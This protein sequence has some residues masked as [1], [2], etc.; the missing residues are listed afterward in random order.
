MRLRAVS[1]I[2]LAFVVA[3]ASCAAPAEPS[4]TDCTSPPG[5][6][7]T[8]AP[9]DT[10]SVP[11][12]RPTLPSPI[13]SPTVTAET[14]TDQVIALYSAGSAGQS[15]LY[16]L[17]ADGSTTDL[18]HVVGRR[19]AVSDDGRWLA[20]S[21]TQPPADAVSVFHLQSGTTYTVSVTPGFDPY[22]MAFDSSASRLAF[23]E[24]GSPGADGTP[25]A[26]SVVSLDD[27][28][29]V[30]LE[31]AMGEGSDLLPGNPL[32][33]SGDDLLLNAFLPYTE[34]T[35][36]GVWAIT[37][38]PDATYARV[39]ELNYRPIL[40]GDGYLFEPE[41]SPDATGFL[42]LNRDHDYTPDDYDVV[43]YDLAVNQL[44]LFDLTTDSSRLLVEETDGAALGQDIA[45]SPDGTLGLFAQGRYEGATFASL[46][47]RKVDV[48]GTVTD[49]GFI[50]L[51]ADGFL[52]SL[53]WCLPDAALVVVATSDRDHQLHRMDTTSGASTL[54]TSADRMAMLGCVTQR[55]A[56]SANADV[57][58]V[59]A[60]RSVDD[61]WTFHVT[62]DHPD[63]G[64]EDYV[65]GWD[66]VTP[67]GQVLKPD[68]DGE[69]TRTL[70]HP[71]VD[72]QP[73]TRSQSGIDL[74]EG[75]TEVRV[76]AHDIVHGYGGQEVVVDLT[77]P[78]GPSFEV[79]QE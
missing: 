33:W 53:D 79:T 15:S 16:A 20:T 5:A 3:A 72:E 77:K 52:V 71:H 37:V 69:F 66:V 36:A 68:A 60:V 61:T 44:G 58:N 39:D 14:P 23:L 35:S 62:V 67:D 2:V 38:P 19:V 26:I 56:E 34:E 12:S 45:W 54:V 11:S 78:S 70:L 74:P 50:P 25:W 21:A 47:L 22:G 6:T 73:F 31:T 4:P 46:A 64:W 76:R 17:A 49:T 28:S 43:G 1:F 9:S 30:R 75:V 10:S 57:I 42:Y 27:G 7:A 40:P 63:I 59:R 55:T 24:L 18:G 51:P 29:A 13:P 32:G 48:T 41:L 8:M 65:D